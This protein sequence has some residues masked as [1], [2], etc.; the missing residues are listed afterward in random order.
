MRQQVSAVLRGSLARVNESID[1]ITIRSH[2]TRRSNRTRLPS[3]TRAVVLGQ[4]GPAHSAQ[5]VNLYIWQARFKRRCEFSQIF[6]R[7]R[8]GGESHTIHAYLL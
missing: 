8:L 3:Q 5:M 6:A 7:W 1:G 4:G 2:R